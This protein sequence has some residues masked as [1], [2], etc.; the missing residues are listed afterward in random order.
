[1]GVMQAA[2][3]GC[4]GRSARRPGAQRDRGDFDPTRCRVRDG[5]PGGGRGL[6]RA[7]HRA[8][9]GL[10]GVL[11]RGPRR[12]GRDRPAPHRLVPRP[13][14]RRQGGLGSS[15]AARDDPD[16]RWRRQ[17][18]PRRAGR[19]LPAAARRTRCR[20]G[21]VRLRAD[22][23]GLDRLPLHRHAVDRSHDR[24]GAGQLLGHRLLAHRHQRRALVRTAPVA[25]PGH[26]RRASSR[27][28][29]TRAWSTRPRPMP[30]WPMPRRACATT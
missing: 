4:C 6:P 19:R 13:H 16:R 25:V 21:T 8:G 24:A 29:R 27:T 23:Q 3:T 12:L 14:G 7:A 1:M 17:D 30:T 9:P 26:R 22:A 15:P 10:P 11:R 5:A 2:R 20:L 18:V 28:S